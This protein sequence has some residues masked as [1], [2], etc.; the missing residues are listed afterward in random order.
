MN[1]KKLTNYKP[2][3]FSDKFKGLSEDAKKALAK[4][5]LMRLN[6]WHDPEWKDV[7]KDWL[8]ATDSKF[9]D[10]GLQGFRTMAVWYWEK[11]ATKKGS[12]DMVKKNWL[13]ESARQEMRSF[14]RGIY[15]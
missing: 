4:G 1:N 2:K 9:E 11:I 8:I 13:D 7:Y 10:E 3:Y 5:Y 12:C 6:S 15:S 14:T